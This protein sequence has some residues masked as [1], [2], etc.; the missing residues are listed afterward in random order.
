MANEEFLLNELE[1]KR[2][3]ET[4]KN[5]LNLLNLFEAYLNN[6]Y[7]NLSLSKLKIDKNDKESI[8]G[9]FK[10]TSQ[11]VEQIRKHFEQFGTAWQRYRVSVAFK[12][13]K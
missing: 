5:R 13:E 9:W 8:N 1:L 6:S 7:K 12:K 2:N 4:L 11:R 3:V 10:T